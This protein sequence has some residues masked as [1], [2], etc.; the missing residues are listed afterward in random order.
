M[1]EETFSTGSDLL[2]LVVGGGQRFGYPAGRVINIV[3]DKSSGKTFLTCELIAAAYH[4]W[5][6]KFKWAY[7]DAESGFTFDTEALYGFKII[8]DEDKRVKSRTVEEWSCNFREFL[9]TLEDDEV[10]IYV[11]DTLDGLSSQQIHDRAEERFKTFKS[12]GEAAVKGSYQ[13]ESAKFLSQEFFKE[14]TAMTEDKKVLLVVVSQVRDKIDSMF[15]EQTRSGGRALD[16]YAHT[17][18]WLSTAQK[19]VRKDRVV[20]V[21]VKA[22]TKKSKT[23]RPFRNCFFTL[24]FD[25]GLDN[26][27]SNLDFLYDLRTDKGEMRSTSDNLQWSENAKE[28]NPKALVEFIK[29][30]GPE[31]EELF[32]IAKKQYNLEGVRKIT[33]WIV[34]EAGLKEQFEA[35]FGVSMRRGELINWIEANGKQAELTERVR[36]K[37]EAIEDAVKSDRPRKYAE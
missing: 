21:V 25:Y 14:L 10:G 6:D 20:G 7:D 27:G 22:M 24:L 29:A 36:A 1:N 19:I 3:G 37:W 8:P 28:V 9:G 30:Q 4:K 18:L 23:P 2:D 33:E 31:K 34:G 11:L 16:F 15:N 32:K 12:K 26:V 5:K 35:E 17:A 13:M